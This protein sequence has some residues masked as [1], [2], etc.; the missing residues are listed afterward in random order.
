MTLIFQADYFALVAERIP[1][2]VPR[3]KNWGL[4][5]ESCT[6]KLLLRWKWDQQAQ[7]SLPQSNVRS[8]KRHRHPLL[9]IVVFW[10][11]IYF[12]IPSQSCPTHLLSQLTMQ[13]ESPC[14][15]MFWEV[16]SFPSAPELGSSGQ[17]LLE[18]S[19]KAFPQNSTLPGGGSHF[20]WTF[21]ITNLFQGLSLCREFTRFLQL[22]GL[23]ST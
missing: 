4:C 3:E 12:L 11:I 21:W 7:S 1:L 2:G 13:V 17:A 15:T 23:T 22:H 16:Q 14:P 6:N 18:R 9:F 20:V 19:G 5:L 10:V 8:W